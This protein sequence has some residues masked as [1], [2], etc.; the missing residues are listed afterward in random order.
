MIFGRVVSGT[1]TTHVKKKKLEDM[2]FHV[3]LFDANYPE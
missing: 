3:H 1:C 2:G